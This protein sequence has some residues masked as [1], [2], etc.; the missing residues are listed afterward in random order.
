MLAGNLRPELGGQPRYLDIIGI[1]F[2]HANQWELPENRLR[3]E[4]TP[5]DDRWVPFHRLLAEVYERYQR[6]LFVAETSHFG[7]GR[8]LWL[9]ELAAEVYQAR[10]QGV[11]VG[12]VCLYPILD[13]PDWDDANHWHNSGLWDLRRADHGRLQR[14]LHAEYAAELRR[15]QALLAEQ[16]CS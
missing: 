5:R 3:W 7:S 16:G 12:G 8:A 4:D 15:A 1:N 2:Y 10:A 14:H 13:R 11:P 9:R 6:P